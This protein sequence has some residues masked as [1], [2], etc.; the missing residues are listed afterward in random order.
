M[1]NKKMPKY[2]LY[3]LWLRSKGIKRFFLEK[4]KG[5][6]AAWEYGQEAFRLWGEFTIK[7]I[8]ID[9]EVEGLENIPDETCVFMGNHQS[10]LDIPILRC[11]INRTM[12]FVAKKE[13]AK[14][15]VIGY[16]ISHLRCVF[17]DRENVREGIKAINSAINSIKEGYSFVVFPEG[18]R[19][20]DGKIGEFK[21]GSIKLPIKSGAPVIPF[22]ISGTSA[23]FEDNKNFI[24]GKVKLCI[25]KPIQVDKGNKD[26]EK[27]MMNNIREEVCKM[28]DKIKNE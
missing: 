2:G 8:G 10:I 21:Q 16:W 18:T 13:L 4:F 19:S 14:T 28:Y 12:D 17:L 6:R 24:P 9:I 3:M 5:E 25:G 20:K 27:E 26:H 22:A 7:T 15:P 23:C 11:T 1:F